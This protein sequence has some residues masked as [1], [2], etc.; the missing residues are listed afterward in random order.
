MADVTLVT[1]GWPVVVLVCP[2]RFDAA[3]VA[4]L[5]A[6]FAPVFAKKERF[7]LVTDSSPVVALPSAV[8]RKQLTAWTSR[9]D[10]IALQKRF[11]VGSSTIVKNAVMRGTLQ[12]LYWFW[13]PG[14]PQ[15]ASRDFD[16]AWSWCGDQVVNAKVPLPAP[17]LELKRRVLAELA[18]RRTA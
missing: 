12:A 14:S 11:N 13:T 7:A 15:H 6:K 17:I 18:G 1:T 2:P 16:D 5:D 3:W 10:Q 8:E 9:P 4:E